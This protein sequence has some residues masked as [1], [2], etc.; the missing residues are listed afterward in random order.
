[1]SKGKGYHVEG[2]RCYWL[3]NELIYKIGDENCDAIYNEWHNGIEEDDPSTGSGTLAVYPNPAS[4]VL[5]VETVCTPS[6]PDQT[7]RI[8]N[9]MGQTL[10]QGHVNAETQ[11]IDIANLTKGMYFITVGGQTMK[12]VVE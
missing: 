8:T 5:F 10:L 4:N 6:L 11:Q 12:F 7:Y 3:G 2:L 9:L 1:M